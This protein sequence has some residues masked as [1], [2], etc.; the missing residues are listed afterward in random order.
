MKQRKLVQWALAYLAGAW[1]LLQLLDMM[2]GSYGW[3]TLVMRAAL[4]AASLGF[5]VVLV[6]AWYHGERGAQKVS[7]T[8]L[9]LLALVLA[10]GGALVWRS[11]V[12]VTVPGISDGSGEPV[13]PASVP[14]VPAKSIA[15]LPFENLSA[16]RDNEYFV[17]GM[18]DL[19]LTK[20]AEIGELKVISRTST[21]KYRSRPENLRQVGAELGVANVLEGSVQRRGNAVLISVQLVDAATDTHLWAESYQRTL[22]NVFG[23]EGEVAGK[24]ADALKAKLSPAVAVRLA[25]SLSDDPAADDLYLRAEYFTARGDTDFDTAQYKQAIPLYRQAIARVPAFPLALARLSYAESVLAWFGGG[26]EDVGR[27]RADAR[28]HAE[29]V[30]ALAPEL[31]E[32]QLAMGFSNYYGR[33]D[34]AAALRNFQAALKLRP[35]DDK[36]LTAQGYVLRRQGRFDAAL[37]SLARAQV[38]DPR[39]SA[40]ALTQGETLMM[41]FRYPEAGAALRRALVLDPTNVQARFR[42]SCTILLSRGDIPAALAAAQG[43]EPKLRVWRMIL[44]TYQRN[45]REALALLDS[46][47]DTPDNFDQS[48]YGRKALMKADLY[49]SLGDAAQARALYAQAMPQERA[50]LD[51]VG[52][53]GIRAAE[54]WAFVARA[55]LGLGHTDKALEALARS[56]AF[57][58]EARDYSDGPSRMAMIAVTYAKANRADLAV[59]MLAKALDTPGVGVNYAPAMLWLDPALDPIRGDAG[60]RALLRR[61]AKYKP[62]A[63]VDDANAHG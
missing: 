56:R 21:M 43:D 37:D 57:V 44:L 15:V 32:A 10:V 5:V 1:A 35:N 36:A 19:I 25:A 13:K 17:A 8:E 28:E 47:P 54:A 24:V 30:L 55:E 23:V 4:G 12:Q 50:M 41:L 51:A 40:L 45:Y 60:F 3:P 16:D 52:G 26:G 34:Y 53:V 61:Y 6:L 22:D 31:P 48:N 58:E 14:E 7:G 62:V 29:Q 38:R 39:N 20:L 27:L 49:R 42:L 11:G 33:G 63:G 59:P 9:L 18:Q 2:A 46:V